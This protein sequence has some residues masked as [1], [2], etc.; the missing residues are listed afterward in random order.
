MGAD[1]IF[2]SQD[3]MRQ[4]SPQAS[5]ALPVVPVALRGGGPVGARPGT[6][7]VFAAGQGVEAEGVHFTHVTL[8]PDRPWRTQ[9]PPRRLLTKAPA[10]VASWP[11]MKRVRVRRP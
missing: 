2:P 5:P 7:A 8:G 6:I 1:S 11:R 10:A 4:T 3:R 9:A